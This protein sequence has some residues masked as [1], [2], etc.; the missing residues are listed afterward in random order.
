MI[1][2]QGAIHLEASNH[3][4]TIKKYKNVMC[5]YFK[6]NSRCV[7]FID[8]YSLN[9]T[10]K[11]CEVSADDCLLARRITR[12]QLIAAIRQQRSARVLWIK[13]GG[14]GTVIMICWRGSVW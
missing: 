4:L 8:D 3:A 6:I 9:K 13:G 7:Q 12:R 14:G 1:D 2:L 11:D 10:E 5:I